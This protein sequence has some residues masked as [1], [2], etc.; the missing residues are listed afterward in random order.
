[1]VKIAFTINITIS[2]TII[3][4]I[5]FSTLNKIY[6]IL[7]KAYKKGKL[8]LS[9]KRKRGERGREYITWIYSKIEANEGTYYIVN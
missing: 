7:Q 2:C 5:D 3:S 9:H 6:T 4:S 8:F 1:M